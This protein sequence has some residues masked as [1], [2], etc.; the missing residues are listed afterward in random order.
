MTWKMPSR[1]NLSNP[2]F[3]D[4]RIVIPRGKMEDAY[5]AFT[6]DDEKKALKILSSTLDKSTGASS[7]RGV[8]IVDGL[9]TELAHNFDLTA[10]Q[11]RIDNL[12]WW[13]DNN[14]K[15]PQYLAPYFAMVQSSRMGK[16]KLMIEFRRAYDKKQNGKVCKTILCLA[17]KLKEQKEKQY[18]NHKLITDK[19]ESNAM[20]SSK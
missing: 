14:N 12:F 19:W 10:F 17:A 20:K 11:N 2:H 4:E 16:T 18:L 13:H 8:S 7:H 9:D 3:Y 1:Q 15:R 6:S 5:P